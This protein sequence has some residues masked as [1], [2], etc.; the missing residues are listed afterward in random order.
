[1]NLPLRHQDPNYSRQG[2]CDR[3]CAY[4]DSLD[5]SE[6]EQIAALEVYQECERV[7]QEAPEWT[8]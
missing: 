3:P 5:A 1:M 7:E 4:C 8:I 2:F 6:A